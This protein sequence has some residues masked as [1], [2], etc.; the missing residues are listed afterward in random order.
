MVLVD[1]GFCSRALLYGGMRESSAD[2]IELKET[3]AQAFHYL[4]KYIYTGRMYLADLR[5]SFPVIFRMIFSMNIFICEFD[6]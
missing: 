3:N 1:Y 4:L 5:V 2:E 6:F